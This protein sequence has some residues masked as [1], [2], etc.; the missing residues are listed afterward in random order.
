V[1]PDGSPPPGEMLP[2]FLV[3]GALRGRSPVGPPPPRVLDIFLLRAATARFLRPAGAESR[4][5]GAFMPWRVPD[6]TSPGP[7]TPP[8]RPDPTLLDAAGGPPPVG[9]GREPRRHRPAPGGTAPATVAP[10]TLAR[11]PDPHEPR[12]SAERAAPT[13]GTADPANTAAA[14]RAGG[15]GA[16]LA[17]PLH[18][19]TPIVPGVAPVGAPPA[20]PLPFAAPLLAGLGSEATGRRP[21]SRKPERAAPRPAAGG[22]GAPASLGGA[23]E[24]RLASPPPLLD[25]SPLQRLPWPEPLLPAASRPPVA[26]AGQ[27]PG[28]FRASPTRGAAEVAERVARAMAPEAGGGAAS[29]DRA[30]ERSAN[31]EPGA[32]AV[33]PVP[34]NG[35]RAAA[36]EPLTVGVLLR[37]VTRDEVVRAL[38]RRIRDL[39]R[40]ERFRLGALR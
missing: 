38:A 24:P 8:T 30:A 3:A 29:G 20:P 5:D 9:A 36:E 39:A 32:V 13:A 16:A 37:E 14:G 2:V 22:A 21:A 34:R 15:G 17:P 10:S 6:G 25:P 31:R 33:P 11:A 23:G 19:R 27:E 18:F 4:P 1:N 40:D 35:R 28:P 26:G 7:L 12:V